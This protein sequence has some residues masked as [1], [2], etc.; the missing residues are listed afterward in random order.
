MKT[1][2]QKVKFAASAKQLYDMYMDSKKHTAS[3]GGAAKLG[4]KVGEAFTAWDGYLWGKNL[5]LVPGRHIVQTWRSTSFKKQD[6]DSVLSLTLEDVDG[7]ALLTMSHVGVPDHDEA[8][9]KKGWNEHYW[10]PWKK[11]LAKRD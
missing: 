7:G 6:L 3:T 2:V 11:Y 8:K 1:I 10:R 5:L 4:K 9:L